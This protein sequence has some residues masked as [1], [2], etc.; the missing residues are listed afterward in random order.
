MSVLQVI[1]AVVVETEEFMLEI[2]ALGI[3]VTTVE[4]VV[5]P[6]ALEAVRV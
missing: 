5:V 2:V 6:A 3:T 4:V 1:V